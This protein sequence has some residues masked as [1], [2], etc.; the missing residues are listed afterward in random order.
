[1]EDEV[2][3]EVRAAREAYAAEHGFSVAQ[4]AADLETLAIAR[5]WPTVR[6]EPRPC[7]ALPSDPAQ[8]RLPADAPAARR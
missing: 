6:H 3:A 1:V 5:N 2:V 8:Q 7:F 4:I